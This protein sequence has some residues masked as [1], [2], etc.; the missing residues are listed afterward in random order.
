MSSSDSLAG[1][2]YH[3]KDPLAFVLRS[4]GLEKVEAASHPALRNNG[5]LS[6]RFPLV[7]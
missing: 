6:Q 5:F 1:R 7:K 3:T 4:T 2:Q